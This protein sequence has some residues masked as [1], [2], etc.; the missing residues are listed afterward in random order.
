MSAPVYMIAIISIMSVD[1]AP[2]A[3]LRQTR[4]RASAPTSLITST[5]TTIT[6]GFT[7]FDPKRS[8]NHPLTQGQMISSVFKGLLIE[9]SSGVE[10]STTY[11]ATKG[12]VNDTIICV[13]WETKVGRAIQHY[14]LDGG[15]MLK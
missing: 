6:I 15:A 2:G 7:R 11:V 8:E 14:A 9:Q 5:P 3:H 13:G 1:L 4:R 12:G 10:Q